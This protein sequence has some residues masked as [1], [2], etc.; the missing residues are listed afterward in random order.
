MKLG[1]LD[2]MMELKAAVFFRKCHSDKK[3]IALELK[4]TDQAFIYQAILKGIF[5]QNLIDLSSLL[6][7]G[8]S[9]FFL[10]DLIINI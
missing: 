6:A 5:I 7:D 1:C 9:E 4:K 3:T 8:I 10:D 2:A